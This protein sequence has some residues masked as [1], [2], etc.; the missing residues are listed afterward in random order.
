MI[1][2]T[3]YDTSIPKPEP[4]G[5]LLTFWSSSW[6]KAGWSPRILLPG[7]TV[8]HPQYEA[9]KQHSPGWRKWLA[10]ALQGGG[11]MSEYDVINYGFTS[12]DRRRMDGVILVDVDHV[13]CVVR[14]TMTG[15]DKIISAA[16]AEG[17][18][19]RSYFQKRQFGKNTPKDCV[20]FGNPG[21]QEAP[22]VHF[23]QRSCA[24]AGFASKREA[25]LHCGRPAPC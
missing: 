19:A 1:V 18:S 10:L 24:A 16:I 14:A 6:R 3:Y 7:H 12:Q 15:S 9:L 11:W 8:K 21:W 2:F 5:E 23:S 13:P 20:E 25:M 22:L 17:G 4:Q